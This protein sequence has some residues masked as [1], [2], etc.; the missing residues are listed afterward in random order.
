MKAFKYFS[1]TFLIFIRHIRS[2]LEASMIYMTSSQP[3]LHRAAT[4]K[5][6]NILMEGPRKLLIYRGYI[7][8]KPPTPVGSYLIGA[9]AA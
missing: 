7:I 9:I 2:F 4:Y 6:A 3:P 8:Y 1:K 5:L